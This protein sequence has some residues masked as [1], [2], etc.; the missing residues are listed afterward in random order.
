MLYIPFAAWRVSSYVRAL[1][2]EC[3]HILCITETHPNTI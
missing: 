2:C 1:T 3:V